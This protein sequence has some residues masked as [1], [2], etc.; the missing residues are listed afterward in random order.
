MGGGSVI[1]YYC[2]LRIAAK[3]RMILYHGSSITKTASAI[4]P[5]TCYGWGKSY[6]A[7]LEDAER[8][9][10]EFLTTTIKKGL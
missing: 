7:S 2:V 10:V 5:G 4:E 6:K 1:T 3:C 8:R 9:R